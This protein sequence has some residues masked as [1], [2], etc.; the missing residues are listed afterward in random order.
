MLFVFAIVIMQFN[1]L[2]KVMKC[3]YEESCF[4]KN[5]VFKSLERL[6]KGY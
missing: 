4:Y 1:Q 2:W 6:D 3:V 5:K